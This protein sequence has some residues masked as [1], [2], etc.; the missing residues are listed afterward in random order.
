M[1]ANGPTPTPIAQILNGAQEF[2][3][4]L[5]Q[6]AFTISSRNK[7]TTLCPAITSNADE[8]DL[9]VWLHCKHSQGTKVL[10]YSPDTDIYH[11]GMTKIPSELTN[12]DVIV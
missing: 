7:T 4:N 3:T 9:R 2:T 8:A 6:Q 5:K 11:I 1:S 10:I 12:K